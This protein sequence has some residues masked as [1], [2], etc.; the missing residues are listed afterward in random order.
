M[1]NKGIK[2]GIHGRIESLPED[3]AF[4]AS[5]FADIADSQNARQALKELADA[6]TIGRATRGVYYKPRYSELLGQAVPPDVDKVAHAVA[7]ARGWEIAPSGDHALNML[8]LDTQV[9]AVYAYISSGPYASV[10]IGPY[11]VRFKHAANRNIVGMSQTSALVVQ[12]L[13]ALG[14]DGAD[15]YIIARISAR[16]SAHDK[17]NLLAETERATSWVREAVRKIAL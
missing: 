6:G 15:D 3:A 5:D 2:D 4:T 7:R 12:A 10:R 1:N 17:E 8:G 13:K 9:P 16:L 14:K 11:D